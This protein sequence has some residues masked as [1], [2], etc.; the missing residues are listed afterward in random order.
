MVRNIA[1]KATLL[2][3]LIHFSGSEV[4]SRDDIE[5]NYKDSKTLIYRQNYGTFEIE[6]LPEDIQTNIF[7]HAIDSFSVISSVSKSCN[8]LN[9]LNL[10]AAILSHSDAYYAAH[11]D[12]LLPNKVWVSKVLK[13]LKHYE[14]LDYLFHLSGFIDRNFKR[15]LRDFVALA[16]GYRHSPIFKSF[17]GPGRLYV[18]A[19]K[20]G[21]EELIGRSSIGPSLWKDPLN[22][23][24]ICTV[25]AGA[26]AITQA[27]PHIWFNWLRSEQGKILDGISRDGIIRLVNQYAYA[28]V[29]S[30]I[31]TNQPTSVYE[32]CIIEASASK[33][34]FDN[35]QLSNHTFINQI[36]QSTAFDIAQVCTSLN[37]SITNVQDFLRMTLTSSTPKTFSIYYPEQHTDLYSMIYSSPMNETSWRVE[38]K[39][40]QTECLKDRMVEK[41]QVARI[42]WIIGT[43]IVDVIATIFTIGPLRSL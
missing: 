15:H 16:D 36:V 2:L 43:I 17:N 37:T 21:V 32:P 5:A 25:V 6:K 31:G 1:A 8:R 4:F 42:A 10:P 30:A 29:P 35:E 11:K 28:H 26:W 9:Q 39:Q 18:L 40:Y 33:G 34:P 14:R 13:A 24:G 20:Y 41:Y 22:L 7:S 27:P 12:L 38:A 23:M 19:E 3:T